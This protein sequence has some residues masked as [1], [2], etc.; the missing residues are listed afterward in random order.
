M[1]D[2]PVRWMGR[3]AARTPPVRPAGT[4]ANMNQPNGCTPR[5]TRRRCRPRINATTTASRREEPSSHPGNSETG[6]PA[7]G[8]TGNGYRSLLGAPLGAPAWNQD[9]N[10]RF[11]LP[12]SVS[13]GSFSDRR[14]LGRV[15]PSADTQSGRLTGR[16]TRTPAHAH[17]QQIT[18]PPRT[19]PRQCSTI[20]S[21]SSGC[22]PGG[23]SWP[24]PPMISRRLP[25]M[26]R[27][28]SRP[29]A[30]GTSG[31]SLPW[32]TSVGATM[33]CSSGRRS[34][35]REYRQQLARGAGRMDAAVHDSPEVVPQ[36]LAVHGEPGAADHA[37]HAGV[38]LDQ[39]LGVA[40]A[41]RARE[42]R[43]Q[44]ARLAHGDA[45]ARVAR[46]RHDGR[47]A[48]DALRIQ[49]RD[50]LRDHPAH[51]HADEVRA[52]DAERVEQ[53][54]GV[55]GHV[56]QRVRSGHL[57]SQQRAGDRHP[58]VGQASAGDLARVAAVAIVEADHPEAGGDESVDEGVRPRDARHPETHDQQDRRR[59][60]VAEALVVEL[61]TPHRRAR[62]LVLPARP[63]SAC[64]SANASRIAPT[65]AAGS[66]SALRAATTPKSS[67]PA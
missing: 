40:G 15:P 27:A 56:V 55:R 65:N 3:A 46:R 6:A 14:R 44:R 39:R 36:Q 51:R 57:A 66:R 48:R 18:V 11:P 7:P 10:D 52:L 31:S 54:D 17:P 4:R 19:A 20:R 30:T 25:R 16:A 63:C 29:A 64:N 2:T 28:V 12:R 13:K 9:V 26:W 34:P 5:S 35:G 53:A 59:A 49:R 21:T 22:T 24:M 58:Q 60:D 67:E 33:R 1:I 8:S 38:V 32:T 43:A 41:G 23:R 42:D 45:H 61:D 37:E 62:H 50:V 47:E